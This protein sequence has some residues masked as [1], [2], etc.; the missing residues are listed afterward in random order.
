M[1]ESIE[2]KLAEYAEGILAKENPTME[3]INFIVFMLN[4][5]EMKENIE[6]S[7]KDRERLEK[8]NKEWKANMLNMIGT[9]GGE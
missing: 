7:N 1:K 5:I 9:I 2:K 4:R 3:D 8:S 6:A